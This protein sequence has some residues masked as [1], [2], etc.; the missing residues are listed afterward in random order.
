MATADLCQA[1][2]LLPGEEDTRNVPD[3]D[4]NEC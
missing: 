1:A 3:G 2:H 4:C